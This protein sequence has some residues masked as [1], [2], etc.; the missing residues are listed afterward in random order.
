MSRDLGLII[1]QMI[2]NVHGYS[3]Q[4]KLNNL[5]NCNC[6]ERHQVNKPTVLELWHE[7]PAN[8]FHLDIYPCMCNCRHVSR[9]ICRQ[10]N[11][12]PPP[13]TRVNS[14]TNVIDF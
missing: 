11:E 2:D 12:P 5:A 4:D 1:Q 10:I 9:F 14:P 7:T 3:F 13:T 8:N 6:C